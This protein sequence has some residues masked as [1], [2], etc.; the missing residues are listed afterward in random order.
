[1]IKGEINFWY[2]RWVREWVIA[3]NR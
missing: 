2:L 3:W 1:M